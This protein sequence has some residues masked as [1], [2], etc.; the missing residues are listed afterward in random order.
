MK[1]DDYL[2]GFFFIPKLNLDGTLDILYFTMHTPVNPVRSW[3]P[4]T[5]GPGQYLYR[6]QRDNTSKL[7][8]VPCGGVL[9]GS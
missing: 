5:A 9:A 6:R 7:E 3:T 1:V 4:S 8:R 2:D